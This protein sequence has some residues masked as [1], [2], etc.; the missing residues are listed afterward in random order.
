M[1][2]KINAITTG[3]GGIEVTGDSSGEIEFQAD[4]S[5]IATITASGLSLTGTLPIADGGTGQTTA[6]GARTALGLAIGT[7]VQAYDANTAK[8]N[9]T[10]ANFTGT[11]QNSGNNVL[12]TSST[13]SSSN[14]SG[15]LPAID[16]SAL[17]G[18][19]SYSDSDALSLFN[20]SG[21]A[22]VYA[23]R[24]WV[25]FNGGTSPSAGTIQGSGNVSSVT[26]NATGQA[27]IN[28][29]TAMPNA[30]YAVAG[31][32]TGYSNYNSTL[33]VLGSANGSGNQQ[34]TTKTTSAV[35]VHFGHS[36][37][38]TNQHVGYLTVSI[39]G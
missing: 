10:T 18:I 5:T 32:C 14:L 39:F 34:P 24:A 2:S 29:A 9:D 19:S 22:P 12:T 16:G 17:T 30:D 20:A 3:A 4:G 8:Y 37:T 7:D 23:C 6:S 36:N 33:M 15:A 28:F 25:S 21:S 1:T 27:T 35:K 11:L 13:L 38:V 31:I 26:D